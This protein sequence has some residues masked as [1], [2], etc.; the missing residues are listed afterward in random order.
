MSNAY[1]RIKAGMR[2]NEKEVLHSISLTT[3]HGK[4]WQ[5]V[6]RRLSMTQWNALDRL[7]RSGAVIYDEKGETYRVVPREKRKPPFRYC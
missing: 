2:Q 1:T 3:R 7:I 4:R 6:D 5:A